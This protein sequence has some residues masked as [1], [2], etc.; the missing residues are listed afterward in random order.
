MLGACTCNSTSAD[1]S[2][3]R[4]EFAKGRDIFVVDITDLLLA[5]RTRLLLKFLKGRSRHLWR[6]LL[7][8]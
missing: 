3:I 5:E 2:A 7:W 1:L 4:D 6:D 8:F